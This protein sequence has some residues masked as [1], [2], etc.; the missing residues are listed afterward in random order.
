MRRR[1]FIAGL[2]VAATGRAQAQQPGKVYRIAVVYSAGSVD[3]WIKAR[4]SKGSPSWYF[5]EELGRLGFVDGQNLVVER[6]SGEGR[7]EH[8]AE[9]ARDVVRTNPDLIVALGG[10]MTLA[11]KAA[12]TTVPIVALTLDPVAYGIV[13]SLARPGSNITGVSA[14]AG[15]EL[16]GKYL[17]LLRNAIPGVS[18]VG[19]LASRQVWEQLPEGAATRA[20]A[21]R[22]QVSL[23]GPTTR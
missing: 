11:F 15:P 8:F 1:D 9:V 13:P 19:F 2:L 23:I 20:A 18:R 16:S 3:Q 14:N 6:H 5:Y 21:R 7:E 12:T 22:A 10:R 17:E 4:N